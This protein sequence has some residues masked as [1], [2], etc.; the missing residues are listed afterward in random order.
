[1]CRVYNKDG[2]PFFIRACGRTGRKGAIIPISE[3]NFTEGGHLSFK[4]DYSLHKEK[5]QKKRRCSNPNC[6][7]TVISKHHS[8]GALC[9]SCE[10]ELQ[11]WKEKEKDEI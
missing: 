7:S 3:A 8:F 5:T 11:K 2:I 9:Q 10:R 1:M 6:R 4:T